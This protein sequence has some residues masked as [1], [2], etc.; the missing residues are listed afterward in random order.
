MPL[1]KRSTFANI[2]R[3][4]H[5]HTTIILNLLS[6]LVRLSARRATLFGLFGRCEHTSAITRCKV[7]AP[8]TININKKFESLY[9]MR[10]KI[11]VP[12]PPRHL[13]KSHAYE[14]DARSFCLHTRTTH[15]EHTHFLRGCS[16]HGCKRKAT[17]LRTLAL[18]DTGAQGGQRRKTW[19]QSR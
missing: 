11:H 1:Q 18:R 19:R 17:F 16:G 10:S 7:Q 8:C 4:L 9:G 2:L 15:C 3:R 6:R 5:M 13:E 14:H 12:V